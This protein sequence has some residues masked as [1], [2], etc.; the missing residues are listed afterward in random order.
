MLDRAGVECHVALRRDARVTEGGCGQAVWCLCACGGCGEG[1]SM[2]RES[3]RLSWSRAENRRA[4]RLG[5]GVSVK[6]NQKAV[7]VI[8]VCYRG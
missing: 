7:D 6:I 5:H 4:R 2:G 3:W 8:T 1:S